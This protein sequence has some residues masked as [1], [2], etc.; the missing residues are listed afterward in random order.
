LLNPYLAE[1]LKYILSEKVLLNR[2]LG[3]NIK[4]MSLD[5]IYSMADY[6]KSIITKNADLMTLLITTLFQLVTESKKGSEEE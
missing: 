1:I 4:E 3:D 5:V 2:K 6:R